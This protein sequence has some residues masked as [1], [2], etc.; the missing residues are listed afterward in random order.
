MKSHYKY[1]IAFAFSLILIFFFFLRNKSVLAQGILYQNNFDNYSDGSLPVDWISDAPDQSYWQILQNKLI[2]NTPNN[3]KYSHILLNENWDNYILNFKIKG[4]S[5]VDR[6]VV[7]RVDHNRG[8]GKEEYYF[9][10]TE[11]NYGFESFIEIGKGSS[12]KIQSCTPL[13][14]FSSQN[15]QTHNFQIDLNNNN[16]KIYEFI[17]G[18]KKLLFDCI[19]NDPLL[20]GGIGFFNQPNGIGL[21]IPTTFEIDNIEVT[22]QNNE[23]LLRVPDLKQNDTAWSKDIYDHA[24]LWSPGKYTIERWG[25][26]LVSACMILQYYNHN[27]LPNEL[28]SWLIKQKDGYL[29]NGLLN[30]L[31]ISRY[32]RINNSINS[33][34]PI[35]EIDFRNNNHNLLNDELNS[36]PQ[37]RPAVLKLPN[38]F[39]VATGVINND[40]YIN[41]PAST[42]NL[43]SNISENYSSLI[44]FI[45]S[46]TDL[47]Y[48]MITYDQDLN[49]SIKDPNDNILPNEYFNLEK[50]PFDII[51]D[52]YSS[53]ES[54]GIF[55]LPK[56]LYGNYQ[57]ELS[58]YGIYS[59]ESYSY[60]KNGNSVISKVEGILSNNQEQI[61]LNYGTINVL[62]KNCN[63]DQIINEL[64]LAFKQKLI[65]KK[66]FYKEITNQLYIVKLLISK[67]RTKPAKLLLKS[68]RMRITT[69][70]KNYIDKRVSNIIKQDISTLLKT[71]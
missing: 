60:D 17:D 48:L 64:K 15:G 11:T 66:N 3:G 70:P 49:I 37:G 68:I 41:D 14:D 13:N 46:F 29:K 33:T 26:S 47:S 54:I 10:Y 16:I 57:I 44:R 31:A 51:D 25:C 23:I 71:L 36:Q 58:K 56:P 69:L 6:F 5:G 42:N 63:I 32:S 22:S 39:V 40:Y 12:G 18:T 50:P 1:F 28:N 24:N 61:T 21:N 59:I 62:L 67:K 34:L 2:S 27:I 55:L 35:L 38:H 9:K 45:P 4:I 19:D 30:W 65:Y 8:P 53:N 52:K 20:Y 43:L 7:F